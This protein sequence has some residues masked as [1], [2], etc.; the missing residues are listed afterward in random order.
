MSRNKQQETNEKLIE[1][2]EGTYTD[3]EKSVILF[4]L[5]GEYTRDY[6]KWIDD[7]NSKLS[8]G[9]KD[10]CKHES[11]VLNQHLAMMAYKAF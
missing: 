6:D 4:H 8:D 2:F 9:L 3:A 7:P 5:F 1:N 11:H 10:A